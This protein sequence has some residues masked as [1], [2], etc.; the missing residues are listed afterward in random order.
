MTQIFQIFGGDQEFSPIIGAICLYVILLLNP[1]W[2]VRTKIAA[3]LL[4]MV[5]F[6][7]MN[8]RFFSLEKTQNLQLRMIKKNQ[9]RKI[10]WTPY[11]SIG[12]FCFQASTVY[13]RR[14]IHVLRVSRRGGC[15]GMML[16]PGG[17]IRY[18]TFQVCYI[19]EGWLYWGG[20]S[21]RGGCI[22]GSHQGGVAVLGGYVKEGWLYWTGHMKYEFHLTP[23]PSNCV[24]YGIII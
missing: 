13:T 18:K 5:R 15:I 14:G 3:I 12:I 4:K 22:G 7:W 24:S 6:W 17:V 2:K 11:Y 9:V 8:H 1:L 16:H 10:T 19:K 21:R 20:T 23:T